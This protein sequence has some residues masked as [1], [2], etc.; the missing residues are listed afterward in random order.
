MQLIAPFILMLLIT[1]SLRTSIADAD[2]STVNNAGSEFASTIVVDKNGGGNFDSIQSAIDSISSNID[3]C[4]KVHI[5]P[6]VYKEKATIPREKPCIVLEGQGRDVTTITFD[7]HDRTE[8]SATSTSMADNIVAKGIT[9]E[10]SYKHK[11]LLK[12]RRRLFS[13][14]QLPGVLQAVAARILGDKSAYFECG[15]LGL[16]DTLWDARGRHYFYKCYIE[17][18]VDFIFGSGQSVYEDCSIY[19]IAGELSPQLSQAYITAQ[20]RKSSDDPSGFVFKRGEINGIVKSYL[21]RAYGPY[22]TVIFQE[23]TMNVEV[24]PEGWF[25]WKYPGK[26]ENFMY[27]EVNCQGP[28]SDTS[29]RVPWEKKLDPYQLDEFSVSS[30]VDQDGWID[31]LQ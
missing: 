26:E 6:G 13:Q 4:I 15:F 30:F 19:V 17:G 31:T 23:T 1:L 11:L 29:R 21:G 10:N 27:A 12:G 14:G 18:A 20:G 8:T 2:C 3:K 28:G 22:S 5:N 7:A 9:F 25:A 24:F 16:Q